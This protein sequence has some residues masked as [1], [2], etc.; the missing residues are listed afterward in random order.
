MPLFVRGGCE[1][2]AGGFEG[3]DKYF[4]GWDGGASHGIAAGSPQG[5]RDAQTRDG[6]DKYFFEGRGRESAH[7]GGLPAA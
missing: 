7:N 6:G 2:Y 4:F 5:S 1:H 3:G